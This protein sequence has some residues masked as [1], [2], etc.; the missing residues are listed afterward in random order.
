MSEQN[1]VKITTK[2]FL[3]LIAKFPIL[4]ELCCLGVLSFLSL[5]SCDVVFADS[6]GS[7]ISKG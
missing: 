6:S 4:N 5:F 7:E 1:D 2:A 3:R